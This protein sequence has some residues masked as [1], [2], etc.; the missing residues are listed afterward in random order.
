MRKFE[1]NLT[2]M[3]PLGKMKLD[4]L[5]KYLTRLETIDDLG[6]ILFAYQSHILPSSACLP[7]NAMPCIHQSKHFPFSFVY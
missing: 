2:R 4:A 5:E 7:L 3:V 1:F 6:C